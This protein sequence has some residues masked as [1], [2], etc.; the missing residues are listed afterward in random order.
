MGYHEKIWLEEYQYTR[1]KLYYRYVDDII[2]TFND[3]TEAMKLFT[4]LNTRHENISF[5]LEKQNNN[6]LS[7]LDVNITN[8]N[9]EKVT[10]S[11]HHKSTYTGLLLNYLSFTSSSYK[12]SLI[13]CL[14]DRVYKINNTWLGF[15]KDL[16]KH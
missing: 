5:T 14:V 10:L 9:G 3:E 13:K 4:Y 11:T 6:S 16:S 1:P 7:F 15:H 2:A 8:S 12:T